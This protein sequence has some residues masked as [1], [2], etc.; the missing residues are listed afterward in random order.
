MTFDGLIV[1]L[2]SN[3]GFPIVAFLLMYRLTSTTI[4]EN[5]ASIIELKTAILN[6]SGRK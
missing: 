1:Q 4:K 6:M 3:V 5:T 2:V